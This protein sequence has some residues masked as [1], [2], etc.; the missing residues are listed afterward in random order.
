MG[1]IDASF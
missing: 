1:I